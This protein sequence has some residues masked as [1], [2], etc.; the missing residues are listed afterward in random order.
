M[1][2]SMIDQLNMYMEEDIGEIKYLTHVSN[3]C[4]IVNQ[5]ITYIFRNSSTIMVHTLFDWGDSMPQQQK[6]LAA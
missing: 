4:N 6:V 5:L 1:T 3:L 2:E